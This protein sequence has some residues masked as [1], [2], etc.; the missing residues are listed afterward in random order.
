[1]VHESVQ[2]TLARLLAFVFVPTTIGPTRDDSGPRPPTLAEV[3]RRCRANV[4]GDCPHGHLCDVRNGIGTCTAVFSDPR[5]LVGRIAPWIGRNVSIRAELEPEM[6][7]CTLKGCGFG[8]PCCNYCQ[9]LVRAQGTDF[10]RIAGLVCL[11]NECKSPS[12]GVI[13]ARGFTVLDGVEVELRGRV[14]DEQ[15]FF[16]LK[17]VVVGV[18]RGASTVFLIPRHDPWE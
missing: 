3:S 14:V 17:D 2:V 11:G 4:P 12:C 13:D 1:M 7:A 15:G 5:A 8:N 6:Y 10:E 18:D 9:G 16:R